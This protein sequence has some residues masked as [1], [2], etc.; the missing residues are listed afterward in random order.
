MGACQIKQ[1]PKPRSSLRA[2]RKA[3]VWRRGGGATSR[4]RRGARCGGRESNE[5]QRPTGPGRSLGTRRNVGHRGVDDVKHR[6]SVVQGR[7]LLLCC[8]QATV[9]RY[10]AAGGG[11]WQPGRLRLTHPPTHLP[12][13]IRKFF[14]RRKMT[15]IKGA[16]NGRSILGA[17]KKIWPLTHPPPHP[18]YRSQLPL[19]RGL[20]APIQ[21]PPPPTVNTPPRSRCVQQSPL[22]HP[23]RQNSL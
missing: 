9:S 5:C 10:P 12:T 2:A 8:D 23:R 13:H 11:G 15:L 18:R 14:L 20:V 16:R 19:N 4:R 1:P 21:R 6:R 7:T 17:Q 3:E 22:P